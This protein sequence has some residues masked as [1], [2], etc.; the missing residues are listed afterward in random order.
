M[1]MSTALVAP[2]DIT[3]VAA[4]SPRHA[5]RPLTR[6]K[7][8]REEDFNKTLLEQPRRTFATVDELE[9]YLKANPT[10]LAHPDDVEHLVLEE[11]PQITKMPTMDDVNRSLYGTTAESPYQYQVGT[12]AERL[13]DGMEW[14]LEAIRKIVKFDDQPEEVFY[15]FESGVLVNEREVRCSE[16][17]VKRHFGMRPFLWQQW[18]LLSFEADLRFQQDHERD[19][20]EIDYLRF[21][22]ARWNE[23]L[24]HPN[25]SAFLALYNSKSE[26]VQNK[27][28]KFIFSPFALCINILKDKERWDFEESGASAYQYASILGSGFITCIVCAFLQIVVPLMILLY[29]TRVSTNFPYFTI[30]PNSSS[31]D[32]ERIWHTTW[33]DFCES[34]RAF[35]AVL[36]NVVVYVVFLLRVG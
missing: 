6:G 26:H 1:D 31:L 7:S 11:F 30:L 15:R 23:W 17:A 33:K 24:M 27:L 22:N 32:M 5:K 20:M 19:F 18:A 8:V 16:E 28:K 29:T 4:A 13:G 36:M 14:H 35:D 21:A 2:E 10:L 34:P 12:Y 25:N 3:P 9:H